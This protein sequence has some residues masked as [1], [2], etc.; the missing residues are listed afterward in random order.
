MDYVVITY[1]RNGACAS[2]RARDPAV[3]LARVHIL[4]GLGFRC[5]VRDAHGAEVDLVALVDAHDAHADALGP[6]V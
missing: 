2:F 3:A 1:S 4:E 5:V 6:L